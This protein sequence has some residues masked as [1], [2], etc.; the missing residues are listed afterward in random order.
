MRKRA[1]TSEWELI[2]K[3]FFRVFRV[4]RDQNHFLEFVY[5]V[6]LFL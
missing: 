2:D 6:I 5:T 4:F 1:Q 3:N